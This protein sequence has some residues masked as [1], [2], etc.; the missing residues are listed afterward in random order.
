[1]ITEI[2][3]YRIEI[4][5]DEK[6][7]ID[8]ADNLF[9]YKNIYF[10]SSDYILPTRI[11]IKVYENEELISSSIIGSIGGGT[12]IH[13]RSQIIENGKLIICCSDSVFSL[14]LPDLNLIWKTQADQ[15]T[16]FEI[17]N[18]QDSFIVHGEMEI[19]KLDLN[20]NILWQNSGADIFTTEKGIDD[21]EITDSFIRATDWE[22]RIYKFDF[23]GKLIE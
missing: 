19:S 2:G 6:Y 10:T 20:G 3:L 16:C 11:G 5:K 18:L 8:S 4:R 9:D 22:N 14:S 1:M 12:G 21:F 15:A 23:D 17:F 7:T 13:D